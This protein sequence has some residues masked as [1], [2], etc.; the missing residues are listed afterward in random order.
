MLEHGMISK[1]DLN[2]FSVTDD[3]K[4]AVA[5]VKKFYKKEEHGPNF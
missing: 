2:L 5:I 1:A 4:E 3:P